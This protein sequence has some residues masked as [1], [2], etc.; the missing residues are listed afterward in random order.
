MRKVVIVGTVPYNLQS[1]SRAFESYFHGWDFDS[2]IQVFSNPKIP[3]KGHCGSL[4]QIT[5]KRMLLR[6][7]NQKMVTTAFFQRDELKDSINNYKEEENIAV[8]VGH[9]LGVIYKGAI[10]HL[11]RGI[12]WKKKYWCTDELKSWLDDFKPECVFLAFSDDFFILDIAIFIAKRY[13]IPIISCIGDDYYFN[14]KKWSLS[15]LYHIYKLKYRKKVSDIF[16]YY[17]SAI[18]IGNKI[19]DK[20]NKEFNL[21]GETCYLTSS[22][23]RREFRLINTKNPKICYFGNLLLGRNESLIDIANALQQINKEYKI[24]VYS[25]E[26]VKIAWRMLTEH[27]NIEFHGSVPYSVVK[28]ETLTSDILLVVEGFKKRDVDITRYSLS[29]KVA[30]SLSSG[31]AVLGY[32][33]IECGA[34]EYLI[35]CDCATV[36]TEKKNLVEKINN[37]LYNEELQRKNYFKAIEI[38]ENN[39]RLT[40]SNNIFR[41]IVEREVIANESE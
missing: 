16:S 15:P 40:N 18:Y 23:Q 2:L 14:Y 19:R 33:S 39:H 22:I 38:I 34:I 26:T 3:I 41:N 6:W 21:R 31:V 30:D 10:S 17:G 20:Y 1:P 27:P 25:N 13:S 32:G 9:R 35:E 4:C 12:L 36:C 37:I 28:Q 11:L 8:K 24:H 5:D 29:T 7:F